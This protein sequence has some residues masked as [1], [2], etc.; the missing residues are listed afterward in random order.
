MKSA[1][2]FKIVTPVIMALYILSLFSGVVAA[3]ATAG[4]QYEKANERYQINKDQYDNTRKKFE[5]AKDIFEKANKQLGKLNDEKSKDELKQKA[6]DYLMTAID[7]AQSQLQVVKSRVENSEKGFIPFDA[8]AIIDGQT[9]QLEQLKVKVEMANSTQE[10]RDA[11]KELK[12]IVVNINL[13]TRYYMGIVFNH[14]IDNFIMKSDNVSIRLESAIQKLK[15]QGND[16]ANLEKEVADF[17]NA[18]EKAKE[19]QKKTKELYANHNGF[20]IDGTV[21]NER[22]SNKFLEQGNKLQ[23]ETIKD[24]RQAGNQVIKFVKDLRKLVVGAGVATSLTTGG[25]ATTPTTGEVEITPTTGEVS[26]T[27][28]TGEVATTPTAG[29]VSTT[30]TTG[31]VTTTLTTGGVTTNLTTGG[32]TTTLTQ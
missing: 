20:A 27:P 2:S 24:L 22:D 3:Q 5:E 6:K 14:R 15:G 31:G 9:A 26:T 30:L 11:H 10:F 12:K 28:T 29:E 13:E 23:K 4:E 18:V 21:K 17:K 25:V 19:S 1:K 32:V 16:T 8:M 7:F